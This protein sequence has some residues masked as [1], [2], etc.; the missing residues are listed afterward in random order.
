MNILALETSCDETAAA[1]VRGGREVLSSVVSSQIALHAP[2]GGVVPELAA[3]AHLEMLAPVVDSA[4][5]GFGWEAVDA[6]AVTRGPGLAG[7]LVVGTAYAQ[8][9]ARARR[10]PITG[11][12]HLAGH[13]YSA[14]LADS[15]LEPPFVAL[16]VSG[17]HTDTIELRRHG[18]ARR[19]ASTRDDAVGEA[20]DKVARMLGLGYPGGPAIERAARSGDPRAFPLPRTRLEGAFSFSGLKTAVRYSIRDLP[21]EELDEAGVPRR[22]EVRDSLAAAFQT[23]AV[24]QLVDGLEAAVEETGATAIAVVGGVAAN[25]ALAA[26]VNSRFTRLRVSV[27][28]LA[29][30]TDNAAMIGAAA[31][32]RLSLH[33]PDREGFDVDPALAEFA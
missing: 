1:L 5:D 11:V 3:R 13:V 19:L 17:G 33:G 10:L 24:L 4:L 20:F 6:V 12:S 16:V 22:P 30:C 23:A 21:A 32:H 26:A 9:V 8:A 2:H 25:Q 15:Q 28:P 7:C 31:W 27:P 14:W 29:L 18:E